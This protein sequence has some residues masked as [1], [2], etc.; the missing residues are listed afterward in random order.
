MATIEYPLVMV[1]REVESMKS[2]LA[3]RLQQQGMDLDSYFKLANTDEQTWAAEARPQ[4]E[5]RLKRSLLLSE[6]IVQE[7]LIVDQA[8]VDREIDEMLEPLGEQAEQL[9]EM[10]SSPSGRMSI[11]E[12][13]LTRK[14]VE[15]LK[16]I[17]RGEDPPK[18]S[19]ESADVEEASDESAEADRDVEA[20]VE[21]EPEVAKAEDADAEIAEVEA[22]EAPE[23]EAETEAAPPAEEAK[24]TEVEAEKDQ[25]TVAEAKVQESKDA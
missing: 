23:Q 6:T 12:R 17:A 11:T 5:E 7:E 24:D 2:Q 1:D 14:A 9:R 25:D 13:V 21:T 15:R 8:E 19:P 10:F 4:G 16:A 22:Q 18:G 3:Q 20:E